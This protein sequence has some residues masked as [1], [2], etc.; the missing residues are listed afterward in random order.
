[1]VAGALAAPCLASGSSPAGATNGALL[2]RWAATMDGGAAAQA[3]TVDQAVADARSLDLI[4]ARKG[5]FTPYLAAMRAA[6]PS[7]K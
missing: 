1:M 5:T 3:L 4:V 6:N 7:V 2:K